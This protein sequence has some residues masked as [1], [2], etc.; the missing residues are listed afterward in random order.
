ML[1]KTP[2]CSIKTNI[3]HFFQIL[4]LQL[5]FR[6]FR[7]WT[8]EVLRDSISHNPG[9][10]LNPSLHRSNRRHHPLAVPRNLP[11]ICFLHSSPVP[12]HLLSTHLRW[13]SNIKQKHVSDKT[14]KSRPSPQY[15]CLCKNRKHT[16]L[17]PLWS[18]FWSLWEITSKASDM[19]S[20]VK[21]GLSDFWQGGNIIQFIQWK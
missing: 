17:P 11:F 1:L 6:H 20:T 3:L 10:V 12:L 2:P 19:F 8:L 15:F 4:I 7:A 14:S 13:Q 5:S 16:H 9:W 18:S 21:S